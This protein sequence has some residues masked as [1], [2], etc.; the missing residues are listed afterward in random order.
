MAVCNLLKVLT[1]R[2]GIFYTFS[3]Y[4]EDVTKSLSTQNYR[5]TPSKFYVFNI[6]YRDHN[7]NSVPYIL[8]NYFENGCAYGRNNLNFTPDLSRNLF[9]NT[10]VANNLLTKT[11]DAN[12]VTYC[13]ELQYVGDINMESY[14]TENG[15]GY[16]E[17]FCYI[18]NDS[19]KV[20]GKLID[21]TNSPSIQL[22]YNKSYVEG[23][24]WQ[25]FVENS[26]MV[27]AGDWNSSLPNWTNQSM[28]GFT[29]EY[30]YL[31]DFDYST[32]AEDT[33][34][35]FNT[36]VPCYDVVTD[37]GTIYEGIPMG[38]YFTGS[39]A[40]GKMKHPVT[41]YTTNEDIYNEG[42]A[43]G[44]RI[45]MRFTPS[46]FDNT[47]I[48]TNNIH[49]SVLN[50][51]MLEFENTIDK[52]NEFTTSNVNQLTQIKELY[53]IFKNSKTN[54]PYAKIVKD[55]YHWF[56]NGKDTGLKVTATLR[57]VNPIALKNM[58]ITDTSSVTDIIE[59]NN[60]GYN[61]IISQLQA[62]NDALK[63]EITKLQDSIKEISKAIGLVDSES[64]S[65]STNF[66]SADSRGLVPIDKL[67]LE[68]MT[69]DEYDALPDKDKD[70]IYG[71][72]E[73]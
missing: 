12:G 61:K 56:I 25:D 29:Y 11:K 21:Y 51:V 48:T 22:K 44:L 40:G 14:D 28:L 8:Q 2:N 7:N 33:S 53:N 5:V 58:T 41:I 19:K 30:S 50:D 17:I 55:E 43:Y 27:W 6:N 52:L 1:D 3:Q 37:S 66:I 71:T 63:T 38:I 26:N 46:A 24:K 13:P 64:G 15:T 47:S 9:W 68:L 32:I 59:E 67:P 18:P 36:I 35:Q 57:N 45:C 72:Y 49:A 39:I 4:T 54:V 42:T 31:H 73:E 62:E 69:E 34:Y 20:L 60:A 16:D 70:T 65:A 10:L 23:Y